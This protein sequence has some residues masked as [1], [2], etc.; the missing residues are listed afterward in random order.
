MSLNLCSKSSY[1]SSF[2]MAIAHL[3][4]ENQRESWNGINRNL[5]ERVKRVY[6]VSLQEYIENGINKGKPI[7]YLALQL[8][9]NPSTL[10]KF[11]K[12]KGIKLKKKQIPKPIR[13]ELK[14]LQDVMDLGIKDISCLS[15]RKHTDWVSIENKVKQEY[16]MSL[17]MFLLY[18]HQFNDKSIKDLSL[19]FGTDQKALRETMCELGIPLKE[20]R[21]RPQRNYEQDY[22]YLMKRYWQDDWDMEKIAKEEG[23]TRQAIQ[24]RMKKLRIK[25]RIGGRRKVL[26]SKS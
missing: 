8:G 2:K 17:P 3:S 15:Y 26:L 9:A 16:S 6:G 22:R 5:E 11:K 23:V 14:N 19:E 1:D 12:E 20:C 13:R 21:G 25:A 18:Q 4:T 7:A 10:Y 24:Q